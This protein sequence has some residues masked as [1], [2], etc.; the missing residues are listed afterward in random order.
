MSISLL[1]APRE[2]ERLVF[3]RAD[4]GYSLPGFRTK[5][6][7]QHVRDDSRPSFRQRSRISKPVDF[8]MIITA[9]P[10]GPANR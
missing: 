4:G 8:K 10:H 9:T 5:Y 6:Q 7:A 3:K 1:R 2:A